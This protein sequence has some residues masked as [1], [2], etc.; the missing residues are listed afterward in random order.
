MKISEEKKKNKCQ[1]IMEKWRFNKNFQNLCFKKIISSYFVSSSKN[2]PLYP[3]L[4]F[5]YNNSN[6]KNLKKPRKTSEMVDKGVKIFE[7]LGI[8]IN[9]AEIR[10]TLTP[11]SMN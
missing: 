9:N 3:T 5:I 2:S 7:K 8:F 4:T 6:M 10:T 1:K 11:L